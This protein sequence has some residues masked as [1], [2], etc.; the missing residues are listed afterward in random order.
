LASPALFCIFTHKQKDKKMT[1]IEE[2]LEQRSVL[3]EMAS[4]MYG[5]MYVMNENFWKSSVE[6]DLYKIEEELDNL[7][8]VEEGITPE[9]EEA[10]LAMFD[11]L[12]SSGIIPNE[13]EEEDEDD[14]Q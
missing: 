8:H 3:M 10:A 4:V 7:G 5:D 12:K 2:L 9:M 11:A 6:K 13:E 1:R 14:A